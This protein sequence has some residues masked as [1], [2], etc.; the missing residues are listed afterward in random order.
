MINFI[1]IK[2]VY[3]QYL[4]MI[5]SLSLLIYFLDLSQFNQLIKMLSWKTFLIASLLAII[6]LWLLMERW[7]LLIPK[8]KRNGRL[9]YIQILLASGSIN[10]FFPGILGSDILRSVM[11]SKHRQSSNSDAFF[12]VYLDRIIGLSSILLMGLI[13]AI[14]TQEFT[15]RSVIISLSITMLTLL[16]SL[17]W[18]AK[19]PNMHIKIKK[20]LDSNRFLGNTISLKLSNSIDILSQYNPT[21]TSIIASF[22]LSIPIHFLWFTIVWI[23][24]NSIGADISLLVIS[25]VTIIVWIATLLPLSIAGIGMREIGFVYLL[26]QYGLSDAQSMLIG[27]FQSF[28]IILFALLGL[29]FLWYYIFNKNRNQ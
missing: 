21:L 8:G 7:R 29:P 12:S 19:H 1:K 4:T 26:S 13:A 3:L 16:W 18:V 10:L 23:V 2:K 9:T 6:R 14:S 5:I 20:W 24:A 11:V 15:Y 27:L 28:I 25:L 17:I 22:L